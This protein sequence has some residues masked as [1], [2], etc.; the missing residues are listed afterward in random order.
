MAATRVGSSRFVPKARSGWVS[1]RREPAS[2][3]PE[4]VETYGQ[5]T[6]IQRAGLGLC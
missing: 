4:R 2:K 3:E 5:A 6:G 1:S